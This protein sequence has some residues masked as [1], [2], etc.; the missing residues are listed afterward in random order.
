MPITVQRKS[1]QF[2]PDS[3]RV[4]ARFF[5]NGDQRTIHLVHRIMDLDDRMV[6]IEL[7]NVL[8]E[9]VY[10]HRN[11][12]KILMR[13]YKNHE[14]LIKSMDINLDELTEERKLL[15]EIGRASCRERV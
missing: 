14:E 9:F 10:R 2:I 15:I 1:L 5:D 7:N 4:V 6:T 11:I 8:R 3:S 13:H 12:S